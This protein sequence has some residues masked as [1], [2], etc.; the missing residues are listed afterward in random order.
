MKINKIILVS[1]FLLAI[2]S[3]GAAS[4]SEDVNATASENVQNIAVED[5]SPAADSLADEVVGDGESPK[6]CNVTFPDSVKAMERN[7]VTVIVP[8]GAEGTLEWYFDG[9]FQNDDYFENG[10]TETFYFKFSSYGEHYLDVKFTSGDESICP[11]AEY[12][13][14]YNIN[15]YVVDIIMDDDFTV[16]G[17][18]AYVDFEFPDEA[19]GIA[20]ITVNGKKYVYD[21]SD[22]SVEGITIPALNTT[23]IAVT[24]RYTG[25]SKYA[26]KTFSRKS[27]SI[28]TYT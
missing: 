10:G 16:Y 3:L 12:H 27:M 24:V 8:E 19:D 5:N 23:T 20:E 4:A 6:E 1:I 22:E 18:E 25:D 28:R 14:D 9:E 21:L 17:Q 15:D 11:S 13:K 2:I 26:D 7:A